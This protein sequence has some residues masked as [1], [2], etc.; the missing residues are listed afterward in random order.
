M[1]ERGRYPAA[2]LDEPGIACLAEPP[3][4]LAAD[5]DPGWLFRLADSCTG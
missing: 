2:L 3:L 5:R 1:D 4:S